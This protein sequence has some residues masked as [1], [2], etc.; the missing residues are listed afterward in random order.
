MAVAEVEGPIRRQQSLYS[1]LFTSTKQRKTSFGLE[2]K[3]IQHNMLFT[4]E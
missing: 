4:L 3:E 2:Q 1:N